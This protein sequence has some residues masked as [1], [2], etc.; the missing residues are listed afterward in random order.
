[1]FSKARESDLSLIILKLSFMK[2]KEKQCSSHCDH[3]F[4]IMKISFVSGLQ[5][6]FGIIDKRNFRLRFHVSARQCGEFHRLRIHGR[7]CR[8][9]LSKGVQIHGLAAVFDGVIIG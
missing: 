2:K 4:L 8:I 1:L 7:A 3:F 6:P 9:N 5:N